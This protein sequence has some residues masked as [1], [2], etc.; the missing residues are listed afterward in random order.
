MYILEL[1]SGTASFSNVARERGHECIT[2]DNDARFNPDI[3]MDIM[4]FVPDHDLPPGWHPDVIWAS[5]PCQHFSVAALGHNWRK[6]GPLYI[7]TS[8]GALQSKEWVLKTQAAVRHLHPTYYFIENPRGM[9]RMMEYMRGWNRSTVTYCQYGA[10]TQKPTDIWN[11]CME[12]KPRP[13]CRPKAPCY[14]RA[15]R[16]SRKGIQG[17]TGNGGHN[18]RA[19]WANMPKALRAIV[20]RQLCEEII[21]ACEKG[22]EATK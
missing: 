17:I 2:L 1:F 13:M 18:Q 10:R 15:P 8:Q 5:P 14:E 9:L 12:W 22:L 21:I 6:S 20:P 16:G 7:P 19:L 4:Q 3:C 11:N